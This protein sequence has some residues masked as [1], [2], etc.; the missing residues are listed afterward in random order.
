VAQSIVKS[1][2]IIYARFLLSLC[3]STVFFHGVSSANFAGHDNSSAGKIFFSSL[4]KSV[5]RIKITSHRE[6]A[7]AV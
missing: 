4:I 6:T 5:S 1:V 2:W 3:F 7:I